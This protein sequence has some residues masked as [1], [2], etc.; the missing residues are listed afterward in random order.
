MAERSIN[1]MQKRQATAS[2]G[3][4]ASRHSKPQ[5]AAVKRG[6]IF[7]N[8]DKPYQDGQEIGIAPYF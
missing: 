4:R 2:V 3:S 1:Y 6:D 8:E 5:S 7:D